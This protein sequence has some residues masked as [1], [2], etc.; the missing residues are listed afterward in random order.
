[1]EVRKKD[2]IHLKVHFVKMMNDCILT[3]AEENQIHRGVFFILAFPNIAGAKEE[4]R[5]SNDRCVVYAVQVVTGDGGDTIAERNRTTCVEEERCRM[6][7][8]TCGF[9]SETINELCN[10]VDEGI[11]DNSL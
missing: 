2:R 7:Y 6:R 11:S 9:H 8:F 10:H 4:R 5:L 3:G 1:M